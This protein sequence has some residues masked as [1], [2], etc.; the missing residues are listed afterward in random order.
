MAS[1]AV[2]HQN[3][4]T[5]A[6]ETQTPTISVERRAAKTGRK[7]LR[8]KSH[9]RLTSRVAHENQAWHLGYAGALKPPRKMA[10]AETFHPHVLQRRKLQITRVSNKCH[11]TP[12][13]NAELRGKQLRGGHLATTGG[14][15]WR[16]ARDN[17]GG[18]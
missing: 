15:A 18:V 4:V 8:F 10:I 6:D 1:T 5:T 12:P 14:T 16:H 7:P 2:M 17:Q 3:S 9:Q 13:V 11:I